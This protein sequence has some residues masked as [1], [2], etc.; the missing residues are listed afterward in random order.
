MDNPRL[1]FAPS[2]SGFLHI[3]GARTALFCWLLARR[4]GGQ[5]ILRIEDTD[6]A[7]S[8]DESIQAILDG[9]RWLGLDWDEGPGVEG[10]HAPYFQSQR[11]PIYQEHIER[12]IESGNV[13]RCYCTREELDAKREAAQGEGRKPSYDRTCRD[14]SPDQWPEDKPYVLRLR[15]P[16]EG[17]TTV[18][19]LIRGDVVF[20]NSELSDQV[21]VRSNGDPL[22]NFVVVVDD[23]TMAVSHVVRGDDHLSNTPKQ[24]QIY[25]ALGYTPP[26]FAHLPL[27]LGQD[28]KRLSKRHGATSVMQYD[29]DGY[30]SDAMVNFLA[31]LGWSHGDQE[32]FTRE[33]L[34]ESFGLAAVGK[35]PGVWNPE[36]LDWVNSQWLRGKS[37]EELAEVLA[38][39][40]EAAGHP[41]QPADDAMARRIGT[42]TERAKTLVD[43]VDNGSWYWAAADGIEYTDEKARRKFLKHANA[44]LLE[45]AADALGALA[46]GEWTEAA[47]EAA[48]EPLFERFD[49]TI[50]KVAQPIR[51]AIT[52]ST[53]SPGIFESLAALGRDKSLTR[54]R[55]AAAI[56]ASTP[57]PEA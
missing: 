21:V 7:R 22:Y 17:E 13:Y 53:R 19:D 11:G 57:P 15:A 43:L 25:E 52:G 3:G 45:A 26:Q 18:H 23:A 39:R 30:F 37:N 5:F 28:K 40:I 16:L 29:D 24:V 54:I 41:A 2:P 50:G 1:R 27:I 47:L 10:P 51:V 14:L 9:L 4:H 12:L 46:E 44:A 34:V 32:L 38:P 35:S 20:P 36:K 56:A 55:K 31:R 42:L 6:A 49:V 8:T 48:I 33:E